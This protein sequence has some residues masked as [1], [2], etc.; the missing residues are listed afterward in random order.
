MDLENALKQAEY[1]V[2]KELEPVNAAL[3][4]LYTVR[5]EGLTTMALKKLALSNC[6][7]IHSIEM[8][9]PVEEKKKGYDF[10]VCIGSESKGKYVRFF[11]Q[12][13]KI[14]ETT[15]NGDYGTFNNSQCSNLESYS[16]GE[17]SIPLYA[18]YNHLN[19]SDRDILPF[20]NSNS[21]FERECFGITLVTT[22]K[23][24]INGRRSFKDLHNA[25]LPIYYRLPF[26]RY[27]PVDLDFYE[28]AMQ[29]AVPLHEL[30]Y[31][32][33]EKAE[34]FN[35]R[36]KEM[37]AKNRLNFFFF[38]FDGGELLD[39]GEELIPIMNTTA[40]ALQRDFRIRSLNDAIK[41]DIKFSS[42]ALIIINQ[43]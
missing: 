9:P 39:D 25:E 32:T 41:E 30:A 26:L 31:F 40:K 13:K 28:D 18:L 33:I 43:D 29:A 4:K 22:T 42:K 3:A 21:I 2:W 34:E 19:N 11:I 24:K 38:F 27:H 1:K 17:K 16:K 23:M 8:I 10:E 12:A 35:K 37:K 7:N 15:I 20:Y 5:E 6:P 14:Q 36:F